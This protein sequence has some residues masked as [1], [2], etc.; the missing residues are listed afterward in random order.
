MRITIDLEQDTPEQLEEAAQ[1]ILRQAQRRKTK[2]PSPEEAP[3]PEETPQTTQFL[4]YKLRRLLGETIFDFK[5]K[6]EEKTRI[7]NKL[8][9]LYIERKEL[10]K[11]FT[12]KLNKENMEPIPPKAFNKLLD[13]FIAQTQGDTLE[14]YQYGLT[15]TFLIETTENNKDLIRIMFG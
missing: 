6:L 2:Q 13:Q 1:L 15:D 4:Y 10:H 12:K 14:E 3:A 7:A 11:L 8:H 5:E 9:T